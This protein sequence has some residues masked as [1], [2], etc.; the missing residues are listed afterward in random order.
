MSASQDDFDAWATSPAGK[1]VMGTETYADADS[2]TKY[3]N[4]S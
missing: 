4:A 1:A 3:A 2:F